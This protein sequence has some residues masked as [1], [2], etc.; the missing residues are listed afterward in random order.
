MFAVKFLIPGNINEDPIAVMPKLKKINKF[1][2]TNP[3][4]YS[5]Q[6]PNN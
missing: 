5:I 6:S 2:L 3:K 4:K 1:F